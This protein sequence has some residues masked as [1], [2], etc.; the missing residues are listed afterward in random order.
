MQRY[1]AL[2]DR[3]IQKVRE[4][5]YSID[6]L[7]QSDAQEIIDSLLEDKFLDENRFVESYIRSKV[8]QKKW[9]V[10]KIR[11]GLIRHRIEEA[12]IEKG[13]KQID[14]S[15]YRDNLSSLLRAKQNTTDDRAAWI[16]YLLQRGY[17]YDEISQVIGDA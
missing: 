11:H 15:R 16:R 5:L 7:S 1:C 2:E 6:D 13:L 9:G 8:N 12:M 17:E 14:A 10:W 3:S 4:K